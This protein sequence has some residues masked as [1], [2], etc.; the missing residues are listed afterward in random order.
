MLKTGTSMLAE[1]RMYFCGAQ[2]AVVKIPKKSPG[3]SN[4]SEEI[5]EH[6]KNYPG[7]LTKG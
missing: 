2:P 3:A 4:L 7:K 5:V 1:K 6:N